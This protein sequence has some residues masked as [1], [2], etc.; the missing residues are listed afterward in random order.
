MLKVY[1]YRVNETESVPKYDVRLFNVLIVPD[2]DI[3]EGGS[4]FE[5]KY[6]IN[7]HIS[8]AF[9]MFVVVLYFI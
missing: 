9:D 1:K 6:M 7:L 2:T 5:I 4:A 8:T 3:I